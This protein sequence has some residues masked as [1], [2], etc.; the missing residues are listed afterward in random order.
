MYESHIGLEIHIQLLTK[1]KAFCSCGTRYGEEENSNICPVCMGYP[2]AL[3]VPNATAVKMA[4]LVAEALQCS[5]AR[6][7]VFDRKNYFY[8]D[9]P[10]NYQISQFNEPV[11]RDG[12]I[13]FPYDGDLRRIRIHD[14]H[15]EEDAGKMIHAG[16]IS[17]IDYNRAGTPL[18]EIVTEPDLKSGEETESFLR[19][20]RSFV[21]Y[22]G[23]SR[24]NMEEGNLRCDANIS[25]GKKGEGL[26]T[27][28]E[29]KNMNS[30]RFVRLALDYE[31]QRQAAVLEAGNSVFQ[32]TRLWNENKDISVIMRSKEE[33]KDYRYFP[34]PDI[35]PYYPDQT[36]FRGLREELPEFPAARRERFRDTYGLRDEDAAYLCEEKVR[37]D[38]FER[39]VQMGAP[40]KEVYD[41]M[42]GDLAALQKKHGIELQAT[43]MTAEMLANIIKLK[44]SET[45]H[46]P[47]AKKLITRCFLE[48]DDPVEHMKAQGWDQQLSDESLEQQCR[49]LVTCFPKAVEQ[50]HREQEQKIIG[51]FMGE[52]M[53]ASRGLADPQAAR[54]YIMKQLE[55]LK[56]E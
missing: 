34:E 41:R 11:G 43:P 32:E 23:V 50:Y 21:R 55:A 14:V 53:K 35:P 47:I 17:L 39:T 2:G 13:L 52:V 40:A 16:E 25:I 18:L 44:Q 54:H 56:G 46:G 38:F 7:L 5:L 20:F 26:G 30:S 51:F 24:G 36:F 27:K 6:R 12:H 33:A 49:E 15:L 48:G 4:Y 9:M 1:T 28:V 37:A 10:K 29:L 22:L 8:P 3:P 45:I 42:S 31:A 19:Y